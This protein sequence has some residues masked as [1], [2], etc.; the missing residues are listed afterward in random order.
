MCDANKRAEADAELREMLE[1]AARRRAALAEQ[2]VSG[3]LRRAI[4]ASGSHYEALCAQSGITFDQLT[5]F[6]A[7]DAALTSRDVDRLAELV[8]QQR[9]AAE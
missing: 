8:H 3:Q 5:D 9:L 6:M 4:A 2:N 7:G 1:R